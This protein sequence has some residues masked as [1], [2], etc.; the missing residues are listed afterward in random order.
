MAL[1]KCVAIMVAH[2]QHK[3]LFLLSF[4]TFFTFYRR[5]KNS[6]MAMFDCVKC[7]FWNLYGIR[8]HYKFCITI[9]NFWMKWKRKLLGASRSPST[10]HRSLN[11]SYY[12]PL[13]WYILCFV[14]AEK[15]FVQ[16]NKKY[17][18]LKRCSEWRWANMLK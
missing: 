3:I 2:F 7:G 6:T 1:V 8:V 13:M 17:F 15:P 9:E 4:D 18:T 5:M 11:F 14:L 12:L 16:R 10:I